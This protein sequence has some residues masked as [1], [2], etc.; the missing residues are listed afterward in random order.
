MI[1]RIFASALDTASLAVFQA[2]EKS[3]YRAREVVATAIRERQPEM[4]GHRRAFAIAGGPTHLSD[5]ARPYDVKK[6][7]Q[8]VNDRVRTGPRRVALWTFTLRNLNERVAYRD[9]LYHAHYYDASG[10]QVDLR[11]DVIKDVFQ[12]GAT[13]TIQVNDGFVA[14]P[15]ASATIEVLGADALLP[16]K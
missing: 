5:P 13:A 15:F 11:Y 10:K 14:A 8:I 6:D 1:S 16:I 2:P 9:V 7:V 3:L 12:P 4:F